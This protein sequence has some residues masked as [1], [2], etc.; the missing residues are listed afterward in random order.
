MT[1]ESIV[2]FTTK[3]PSLLNLIAS[4]VFNNSIRVEKL[5]LYD[6]RLKYEKLEAC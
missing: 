6:L 2:D 3:I 4:I 5:L 1:F